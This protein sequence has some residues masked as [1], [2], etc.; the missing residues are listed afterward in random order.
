LLVASIPN[1]MLEQMSQTDKVPHFMPAAYHADHGGS[2]TLR[3][4]FGGTGLITGASGKEGLVC[5]GETSLEGFEPSVVMCALSLR[6]RNKRNNGKDGRRVLPS[7]RIS[8]T[9]CDSVKAFILAAGLG[10]RLRALG[11]LR[12]AFRGRN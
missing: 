1:A 8:G 6:A 10:T 12:R 3:D 7:G 5:S 11:L 2:M 4:G 9:L